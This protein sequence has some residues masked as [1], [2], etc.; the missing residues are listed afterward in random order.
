[1][2]SWLFIAASAAAAA[3]GPGAAPVL[4]WPLACVPSQTCHVQNYFDHA[5]GPARRDYA[6]GSMTY[7]GHDGTD[8][9]LPTVKAMQAG[10][11]VRAAA[12]GVVKGARDGMAD[13]SIRA[14]PAIK[15]RECGN[16]VLLDHGRGWETQYCHMRRG[17]ISVRPGQQVLPGQRLGEVGLSGETEFP[18]L[19]LSVRRNGIEVDPF[20]YGSATRACRSAGTLWSAAA[21]AKL[22]YTSPSILTTGFAEGPVTGEAVDS[23]RAG[24]PLSSRS[25]AIVA[26]VRSIGLETGDVQILSL[27][28]PT[29]QMLK[30]QRL[31]PLDRP[32]ATYFLFT[33]SNAKAGRWPRGRY[34]AE[35]AVLRKGRTVIR[36]SWFASV[37]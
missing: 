34:T 1:M 35:Y 21:R 33:G 14:A 20:S 16:G 27:R 24:S 23:G 6:C 2:L 7:D 13:V 17:S 8:I 18:H 22:A 12:A 15:G 5:P 4:A 31:D 25:P 28:A 19:H 29:G 26:F 30:T 36:R 37:E 11:E 9:R 32:K 3:P 10:V